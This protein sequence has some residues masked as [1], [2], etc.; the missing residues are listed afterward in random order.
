M[1]SRRRS[2]I[3][4][5]PEARNSSAFS[6]EIYIKDFTR[7]I[8]C[9]SLK[10]FLRSN[11][12]KNP[13]NTRR[14]RILVED[15]SYDFYLDLH[16][17]L[18]LSWLSIVKAA[19]SH[20]VFATPKIRAVRRSIIKRSY[21]ATYCCAFWYEIFVKDSRGVTNLRPQTSDF[22]LVKDFIFIHPEWYIIS[23]HRPYFI[24]DFL[25]RFTYGLFCRDS[26]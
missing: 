26:A 20:S 18:F 7:E 2:I 25:Q 10:Y 8:I 17:R 24:K 3:K 12:H 15:Y 16:H 19:S 9:E 14:T 11:P 4:F 13:R 6:V 22:I 23:G 1:S 5:L 21:R